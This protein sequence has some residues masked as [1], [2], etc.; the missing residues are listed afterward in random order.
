VSGRVISWQ[1]HVWNVKTPVLT[2][3]L[4]VGKAVRK[5]NV[6]TGGVTFTL[7]TPC[8]DQSASPPEAYNCYVKDTRVRSVGYRRL[9]VLTVTL[10]TPWYDQSAKPPEAYNYYV[11][12]TWVRSV[13]YRRLK[14]LTV[15][16]L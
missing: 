5:W 7:K 10:K 4:Y 16:G 11:K 6:K 8:Y 13:G 2:V 1:S 3:T 9:K 12:D 15:R 14:V